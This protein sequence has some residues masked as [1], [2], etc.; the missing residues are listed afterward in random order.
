MCT[1]RG[2]KRLT[3]AGCDGN[4]AR[5]LVPNEFSHCQGSEGRRRMRL[6]SALVGN[7]AKVA[8]TGFGLSEEE[9]TLKE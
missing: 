5:I 3:N 8:K 2:G 4:Q 9:R 1:G 7:T 6:S